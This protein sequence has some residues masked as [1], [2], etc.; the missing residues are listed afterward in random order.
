MAGIF[1]PPLSAWESF[2]LLSLFI[3]TPVPLDY[4]R[5]SKSPLLAFSGAIDHLEAADFALSP[6][7]PLHP[8]QP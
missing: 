7:D 1:F 3:N 6:P 8:R 5:I 2:F 4:P